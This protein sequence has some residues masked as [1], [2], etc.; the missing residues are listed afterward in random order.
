M[1]EDFTDFV[2]EEFEETIEIKDKKSISI[3]L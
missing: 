1:F 2:N 3:T